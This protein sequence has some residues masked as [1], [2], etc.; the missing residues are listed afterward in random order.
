MKPIYAFL[1]VCLISTTFIAGRASAWQR[2]EG[3]GEI[4]VLGDSVAFSYIASAGYGYVNPDNFI[5]FP[6][7]LDR[8]LGAP[9]ALSGR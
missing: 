8:V 1:Q 9:P 7:Y 2:D 6:L 4:L 3:R 5:G